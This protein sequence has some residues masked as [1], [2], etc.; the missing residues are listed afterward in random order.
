MK[1]SHKIL[2]GTLVV[3][4]LL[5]AGCV[6]GYVE[7]GGGGYYDDGG[8]WVDNTVVVGGGHGWFHGH[9][10]HAY[11]HPSYHPA[12]HSAPAPRA[13]SHSAPGGRRP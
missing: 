8:V 9:D 11:V 10:D 12:G 5:L 1:T 6:G 3:A 4:G 7:G 2:N 13:E